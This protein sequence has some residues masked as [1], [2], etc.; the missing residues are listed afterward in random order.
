[1]YALSMQCDWRCM[2]VCAL[3]ISV[4]STKVS[5]QDPSQ[6]GVWDPVITWPLEAIHMVMLHTGK[7]LAV[8]NTLT[9]EE[10]IEGYFLFDPATGTCSELPA[11]QGHVLFCSGHS[12]L[13]DGRVVFHGGFLLPNIFKTT[14]YDPLAAPGGAWN[15]LAYPDEDEQVLFIGRFYPTLTTLPDGRILVMAGQTPHDSQEPL[16]TTPA[17]FDPFAPSGSQFTLLTDAK[18]CRLAGCGIDPCSI[19]CSAVSNPDNQFFVHFYPFMYQLST[20]MILYAGED[21][22]PVPSVPVKTRLFNSAGL[23]SWEEIVTNDDPITGGSAALF[24]PDKVI[25]AG[26]SDGVTYGIADVYR[27]DASSAP[28]ASSTAPQWEAIDSLT[29]GRLNFYLITLPNGS[30]LAVGGNRNSGP[31]AEPVL[32]P[33]LL[34][35]PEA[36]YDPLDPA[37]QWREMAEMNERREYHSS[38][39]LLPDARVLIAGGERTEGCTLACPQHTAQIYSPPYLFTSNGELAP[40]P[41]IQGVIGAFLQPNEI[42]YGEDFKV[43]T[44]DALDI[45][46]VSLI[47]LGAATHS[48]DQDQRFISLEFDICGPKGLTVTA[49]VNG[50]IAPPGY[51]MLFVLEGNVPSV[52]AMVR[53]GP[54]GPPPGCI[55]GPASVAAAGSR[56]LAVAPGTHCPVAIHVTEQQSGVPTECF[57]AY[58]QPNGTLG[59]SAYFQTPSQW[60]TVYVSGPE[61]VPY[62]EY[63]VRLENYCGIVDGPYSTTTWW[64]GDTNNTEC[65]DVDDLT[66]VVADFACSPEGF[67][68]CPGPSTDLMD[69]TPNRLTDVDD[70]TAVVAAFAGVSYPDSTGCVSPCPGAPSGTGPGCSQGGM[71]PEGPQGPEGPMGPIGGESFPATINLV[72]STSSIKPNQTVEVKA[73]LAYSGT[74]TRAFQVAVQVSGGTSGS[75]D[76]ETVTIDDT[77]TD[78]QFYGLNDLAATDV[79]GARLAATLFSGFVPGAIQKY[80]GTFT[81]RASADATGTFIVTV[82]PLPETLLRDANSAPVT[83]APGF[84]A[85]VTVQGD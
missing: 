9:T 54:P 39:I 51:Y 43:R 80:L 3:A 36:P 70:L 68:V 85:T 32:T 63:Q 48:F 5:A 25:K 42:W 53:V 35:E 13:A 57:S 73:N 61:I 38:A 58:V 72:A 83:W 56:Y 82:R 34:R 78:Y 8:G 50:N 20:G 21:E 44:P 11:P 64:W 69:C 18:Y 15:T 76:L 55:G 52:A 29:H 37:T 65:V 67:P 2:F 40:R 26:G 84:S 7:V 16:Y 71:G 10:Y 27:L 41:T 46:A 62:R 77:R 30:L 14:I 22:W 59:T 6:V 60:S 23:G 49:P 12:S 81:F 66:K 33:E 75:L 45:T 24:R 19:D 1:M 31:N 79:Q 28:E 17:M 74:T 47:R 4:I